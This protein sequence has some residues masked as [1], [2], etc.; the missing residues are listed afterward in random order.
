M[1]L[2]CSCYDY[3]PEPG[4]VFYLS[5]DDYEVFQGKRR[6][7]CCSCG[8]LVDLGS[9]VTI[10]EWFKVAE[11]EVEERIYGEGGEIP[12]ASTIMCEECS[13]QWFNLEA[14]GFCSS[15]KDNQKENLE[16]YKRLY[17]HGHP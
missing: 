1:T 8:E 3:D 5:P 10:F 7:R 15:P 17:S 6:Q 16:E 14:L 11:H 9:L 4:D 13:D 2:S 12:R